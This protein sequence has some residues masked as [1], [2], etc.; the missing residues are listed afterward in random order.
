MQI[1]L[2]GFCFSRYNFE[3]A[4]LFN[5]YS[6]GVNLYIAYTTAFFSLLGIS[7]IVILTSYACCKAVMSWC[8]PY[9]ETGHLHDVM[10]VAFV[11]SIRVLHR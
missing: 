11:C 5:F 2:Q 3:V 1:N 6:S 7:C 4:L 8:Q 9:L 10:L